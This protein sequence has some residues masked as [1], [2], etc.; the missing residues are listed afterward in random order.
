MP[1]EVPPALE[2][3]AADCVRDF[4]AFRAPLT[5]EDRAR[6]RPAK[7][8]QRQRDHLD[9][10]GYPYVFEDFRFHMTLTGRLDAVRRQPIL[11][12]LR[13]RFHRLGMEQLVVDNVALLRQT[14]ADSPF[15]VIGQWPLAQEAGAKAQT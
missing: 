12:M 15:R 14:D 10:W 1:A 4:D 11:D 2:H 13:D 7:L 8:T 5:A 3:L 6:R 9:R